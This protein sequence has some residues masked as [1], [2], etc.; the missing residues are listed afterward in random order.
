MMTSSKSTLFTTAIAS[1]LLL[2]SLAA[3]A[4][5]DFDDFPMMDE[6][7]V[8]TVM[9]DANYNNRPMSVR[10]FYADASYQQ[11]VKYYHKVWKDRYDDTAFGIWHQITTITSKCMMTVQLAGQTGS[12]SS[13]RLIISNPPTATANEN[14]GE[15]ILAPPDSQIV[16]DLVTVDGPKKGRVTMIAA[17]GSTSEVAAFYRSEMQNKG[18]T[19]DRSFVEQDSR[20]IAF[21]KG[22]DV[23]NIV[24]L[25]AGDMTQVLINEEIIQ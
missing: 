6:M 3:Q 9:D 22:L 15:G 5:C 25:P 12:P 13:G 17:G 24:I 1:L 14:V 2:S 19:I 4:D 10:N 23:T 7:T 18:W 21:R 11:V 16:S 8:Q 20:V